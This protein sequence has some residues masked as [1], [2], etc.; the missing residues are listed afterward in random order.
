[1]YIYIYIY[2]FKEGPPLPSTCTE[3]ALCAFY[4]EIRLSSVQYSKRR[5]SESKPR[6][7]T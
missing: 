7:G 2:I 6:S 4:F 3:G 1:M 5:N